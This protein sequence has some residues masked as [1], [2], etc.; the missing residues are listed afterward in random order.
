[1]KFI[2]K[3]EKSIKKNNSLVCV[4]LDSD[5]D[6]LPKG[7]SQFL[8]NKHIIEATHDKVCSYKLNIAF[9]EAMGLKGL[10][11]LKSTTEFLKEKYPETPIIIDA[12]RGDI[13]NTNKGYVQFIFTDLMADAVT[14]NPYMG[15]EAI[16]PFISMADKGIIV[17]CRTSNP[18]S[19]EFQDLEVKGTPLYKIVAKNVAKNWN[20]N[21]NCLLVVGATYPRELAEV[22]RIAG[23]DIF[24]LVPG[25]GAQG[26]DLRAT[27]KAGLNRRRTGLIINSSRGIIFA[28]NPREEAEKLRSQINLYRK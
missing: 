11:D 1:M 12:K 15:S 6:R 3:L 13:G 16:G 23:Q 5:V 14:V 7:K 26:G 17:L 22:R 4:G 18:G 27:L 9:Y 25:I 20:T 28:K 8:F 2:D 21:K 19:G 24:F 10:K